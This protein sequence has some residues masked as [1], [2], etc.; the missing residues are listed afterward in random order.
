MSIFDMIGYGWKT[1]ASG[2]KRSFWVII[3]LTLGTALFIAI[4]GLSA[5]YTRLVALPFA[6]LAT[7]CIIQR[8]VKGGEQTNGV[9]TGV[10]LPFANQPISAVELQRIQALAEVEELSRVVM[11]WYQSEKNFSV[12]AG[13]EPDATFGPAKVMTWITKGRKIQAP[14]EAVIESHYAKFN[15]LKVGDTVVFDRHS[16]TIVGITTLKEGATVAAANYY[17]S[18]DDAR[19]LGGL[20]GNAANMLFLRLQKGVDS[21]GLQKQVPQMLPGGV[22]STTDSIGGMMKGFAGISNMVSQLMGWVVLGFSAFLSCWLIAGSIS[23]RSSYIG[24]MK[25]VGWCKKDILAAFGAETALLG[26]VGALCGIGI[27]YVI[28]LGVSHS[29]VSL[30]LPWNLSSTPGIP[31]HHQSGGVKMPLPVVLRL[32]TCLI[33]LGAA[34][35]SS[36]LTGL[37]VAGHI[38]DIKVRRAFDW[39]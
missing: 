12:I 32:G 23:E 17:M 30:S 7:D 6:E 14:G 11:L 31:G 34:V 38:A 9:K 33:A 19:T 35:A 36:V 22:I 5:G 21:T 16:L 2:G 18:L 3:G 27:G 8:S 29:E 39:S 1:L 26:I 15:R 4:S 37:V 25:T 10:R 24:L 13:V 20:D 28:I